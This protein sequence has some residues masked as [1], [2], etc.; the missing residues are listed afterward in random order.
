MTLQRLL[1]IA[2]QRSVT[3]RLRWLTLHSPELARTA[4]AGQYLLV[5]CAE[6]GS[7]DP[8]LRRPLFIAAAE[9]ALGQIGLLYEPSERGLAWLSRGRAGEQI[10]VV[11]PLGHPFALDSRTRNLLLLGSGPGLAALLLLA[12]QAASRGCA[13]TLL[14]G[15]DTAE[16]LPPPFLLPREV[17][18][19]TVMGQP[20]DLLASQPPVIAPESDKKTRRLADNA[21]RRKEEVTSSP[22][23]P[24]TLSP[25]TWADQ[26]CAALPDDQL[27]AL[28]GMIRRVKLRWERDFA[29]A[30]L[31]GPL[32]CGVGACGVCAVELRRGTRMLCSDGPV[33]D[34]RDVG[35]DA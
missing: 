11:G 25:I 5:R 27:L 35:R 13:I 10:D 31:E 7:Y 26:I 14:A 12:R 4:R 22:P 17:E 1:T 21:K 15:A 20:I 6:E 34:L 8:L 19:Q 29:S 16:A 23:H 3:A 24:V 30:L 33:F 9:P 2:D 28:A 32:V 18:Y